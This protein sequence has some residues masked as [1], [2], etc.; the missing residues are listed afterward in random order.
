MNKRQEM[1]FIPKDDPIKE[2]PYSEKHKGGTSLLRIY[3]K[4]LF[5]GGDDGIMNI[6]NLQT[7]NKVQGMKIHNGPI[8]TLALSTNNDLITGS[9]KDTFINIA[10]ISN[11]KSYQLTEHTAPITATLYNKGIIVSSALDG[12]IKVFQLIGMNTQSQATLQDSFPITSMNW[13]NSLCVN[14]N[15]NGEVLIWDINQSKCFLKKRLHNG[16]VNNIKFHFD[17]FSGKQYNL[18]ITT[19]SIDGTLNCFDMRV[20]LPIYTKVIHQGGINFI[21]TNR[22]NT[23]VT[24]GIDKQLKVI[25]INSGFK[26]VNL[27][28]A[29]DII[30]CGDINESFVCVGCEDG[31]VLGYE[32]LEK[33]SIFGYS[34]D[35]KGKVRQCIIV[36]NEKKI[37]T[38]GDSGVDTGLIFD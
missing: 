23:I 5:S 24:G 2:M 6:Y 20:S 26:E 10:N 29:T 28:K 30:T 15:D 27:F 32:L 22:Q 3:N 9:S 19:S 25:D 13:K 17:D 14:G 36:P 7:G 12:A 34:C 31:C 33:R 16:C 8:L 11:N 37:I 21:D 4:M 38:G 35:D 18:I 1:Y